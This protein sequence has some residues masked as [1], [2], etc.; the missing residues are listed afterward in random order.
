MPREI[1]DRELNEL[2]MEVLAIGSLVEENLMVVTKALMER[3]ERV[4]QNLINTD[5]EVNRR[6]IDIVMSS[7][8]LIATQQPMAKD[9]RLIASVIE[10]AGE[11]ERIHDYVKGIAKTSIELGQNNELLKNI[12]QDLPHMTSLTQDMLSRSMVAFSENDAVLARTIPSSDNMVDDLF[13]RIYRDIVEFASND[14]ALIPYANQYEWVI[15]N[16][17][18]SADR[19]INICE[20]VIYMATGVYKELDSE[21][22][23]PPS[24]V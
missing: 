17:E 6:Y 15:H 13:N 9:M 14:P 11:L 8:G 2:R 21:Y 16:I 20:W 4:A 18:R 12:F 7:L 24:R 1:F 22:E 5:R 10:I 3:N 23:S 19:V